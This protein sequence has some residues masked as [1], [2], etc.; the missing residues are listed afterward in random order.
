MWETH[1]L[2]TSSHF[3]LTCCAEH[4]FDALGNATMTTSTLHCDISTATVSLT[5]QEFFTI[6]IFWYQPN[7]AQP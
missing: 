2:V 4:N 3:T 7:V 5:C 6:L 1:K